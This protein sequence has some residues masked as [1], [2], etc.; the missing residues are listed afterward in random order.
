MADSQRCKAEVRK[1]ELDALLFLPPSLPLSLSLYVW[2]KLPILHKSISKK[3]KKIILL[4]N[5]PG[6]RGVW[7][8]RWCSPP[9]NQEIHLRAAVRAY[10]AWPWRCR[11]CFCGREDRRETRGGGNFRCVNG[12]PDLHTHPHRGSI[13]WSRSG[14]APPP[15]RFPNGRFTHGRLSRFKQSATLLHS[16]SVGADGSHGSRYNSDAKV[17]SS[18]IIS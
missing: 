18:L 9:R 13:W 6:T 8:C 1:Q 11:V 7:C 14:G 4:T 15:T 5:L 2:S 10:S 3:T 12:L 16:G 17:S